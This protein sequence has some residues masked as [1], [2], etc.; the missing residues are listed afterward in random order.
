MSH[1]HNIYDSDMHYVIDPLT[2]QINNDDA[3]QK[4]VLVQGDHKSERLTFEIPRYIEG[5]D[6]SLCDVVC[7]IC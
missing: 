2:R 3:D 6:M 1:T 5:H 7:V 4:V